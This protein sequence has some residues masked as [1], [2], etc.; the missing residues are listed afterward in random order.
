MPINW[1]KLP[2]MEPLNIELKKINVE[3][4]EK[5]KTPTLLSF[6]IALNLITGVCYASDNSIDMD[7]VMMIES[8]G[9]SSAFNKASQSRGIYQVTPIVVKEF[10]YFHKNS[11]YSN[12]DMFDPQ[13]CGRVAHWYMNQR[14][15]S[16]LSYYHIDDTVDNR[17]RC[18]NSGI[19]ALIENR[20]P[21]ETAEYLRKYHAT[22]Q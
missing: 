20:I 17:L 10:N 7:K 1:S 15:P 14:I 5:I 9:N 21:R 13:K 16:L 18:Y 11:G 19:K 12:E 2:K 22:Q 8:S 6:L 3:S 4:L